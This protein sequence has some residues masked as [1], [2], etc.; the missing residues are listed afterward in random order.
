MAGEPTLL[1]RDSNQLYLEIKGFTCGVQM[2]YVY[3]SWDE[4]SYRACLV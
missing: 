1:T 2:L 4:N 3:F